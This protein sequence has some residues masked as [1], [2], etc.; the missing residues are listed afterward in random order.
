[1]GYY[2]TNA[3]LDGK[4]HEITVR[5]KRPGVAVR[6]RRGYRAA[7]AAEVTAARVA[8]SPAI[9]DAAA[10]VRSA[11]TSLVRIDSPGRLR[12][13]ASPVH[14]PSPSGIVAV[15]VAGEVRPERG[16]GD[17]GGPG[18][19]TIEVNLGDASTTSE[20]ALTS[21]QQTFVAPIAVRVA[22]ASGEL[23]VKAKLTNATGTFTDGIRVDPAVP[24]PLLF[25]RGPSTG[26]RQQPTADPQ[27][28]RTERAH[29][30]LPLAADD[31]P[32]AARLLDRAAN[33]LNVPV[34]IGERTDSE[35]GQRWLTAD[36]TL[37]ALGG[38]D[39]VVELGIK[40][41]AGDRR[42]LIAIRVTR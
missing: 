1:L 25:R 30:E 38:G 23:Q 8:A 13:D 4:F 27:F 21:A 9:P 28:S 11:L 39:Y 40:R 33:P 14:G 12:I 31:K 5:V 37:A 34:G 15:W 17:M 10:A 19:L 24:R 29:L 26:N 7:T 32:G 35:T 6:A 41:T 3:K 20:I 2:S 22:A 16:G 36:M 18:T 42:V